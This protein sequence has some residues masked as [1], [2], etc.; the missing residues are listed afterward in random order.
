MKV[1][2]VIMSILA[3]TLVGAV[4]I[5]VKQKL[6]QKAALS[7]QTMARRERNEMGTVIVKALSVA[8]QPIKATLRVM[9]E[10]EAEEEFAVQPQIDGRL[11]RVLVSE[12]QMVTAGQLLAVLDDET[13]RLQLEQKEAALATANANLQKARIELARAKTEKDRYYSLLQQRYISQ[14]D[15][16]N[17]ENIYLSAEASLAALQ[18]EV[19]STQKSYE[20]TRYQL[21]Q[22]E[23]YS[24][25]TGYVLNRPLTPG[26]N[27]TTGTTLM[28][29]AALNRVKLKF[30]IDQR[31]AS[32]AQKGATVVFSSDAFPGKQFSGKV[33]E[34]AP[35]YDTGT[36]TLN[37]SVLLVNHPVQLI[38]G[39]F[40]TVELTLDEKPHALVVSQEAI[41]SRGGKSGVFVVSSE[42]IATFREVQT[43]LTAGGMTELVA[44][45]EEGDLVV[46]LGQN[47]LRG[48]EKVQLLMD[49]Q[50]AATASRPGQETGGSL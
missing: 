23:V 48:G 22:T 4:S 45:V 39:M 50:T 27:V 30:Q 46:I 19:D 1:R 41:V 12:G 20:L 49:S 3:L 44:G 35:V 47:R 11:N 2:T 24:R 9:G 10:I 26:V 7:R 40:G 43:G 32:K 14:H 42:K 28:T 6:D 17:V 15:Y 21:G 13:I 33:S 31:D 29:I 37:L 16:E 25:T 38:P 5:R 34:T 18:A 8:R 36:R